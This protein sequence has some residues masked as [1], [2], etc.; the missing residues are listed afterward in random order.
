MPIDPHY[1]TERIKFILHDSECKLLIS[2]NEWRNSSDLGSAD[3]SFCEVGDAL[4]ASSDIEDTDLQTEVSP[5]DLLYM[6]Y[7]SG[8]TG[9]PKGVM[10]DHLGRVNNFSRSEE[11]RVGKEC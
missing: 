4:T 7:T 1:P 5:S 10:L 11:R 2:S 3:V 6:I 9:A 8:S